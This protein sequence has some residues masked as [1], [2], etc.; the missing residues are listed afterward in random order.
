MEDGKKFTTDLD[1]ISRIISRKNVNK[2]I[3]VSSEIIVQPNDELIK[4]KIRN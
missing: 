3:F 2:E 1:T 4:T